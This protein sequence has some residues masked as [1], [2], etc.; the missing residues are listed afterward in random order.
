MCH[1]STG[2]SHANPGMPTS[3][4]SPAAR[5]RLGPFFNARLGKTFPSTLWKSTRR[6]QSRSRSTVPGSWTHAPHKLNCLICCRPISLETRNAPGP[7]THRAQAF[8]RY[9]RLNGNLVDL[10]PPRGLRGS[11]H[12]FALHRSWNERSEVSFQPRDTKR[13]FHASRAV[14]WENISNKTWS[15]A[16]LRSMLSAGGNGGSRGRKKLFDSKP[17]HQFRL[18][19]RS[20]DASRLT[21]RSQAGAAAECALNALRRWCRPHPSVR[22]P[23]HAR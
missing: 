6:D 12:R 13:A 23:P 21:S 9:R 2:D 18:S 5:A 11:F 22:S 19:L 8:A 16:L 15:R 20:S 7:S 4:A 3:M 10:S 1:V 14:R 17:F